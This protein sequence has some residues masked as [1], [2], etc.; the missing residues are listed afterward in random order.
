MGDLWGTFGDTNPN[1]SFILWVIYNQKP[2]DKLRQSSTAP[3]D[4]P[5]FFGGPNSPD[6][7]SFPNQRIP[8][9][10]N[11]NK[12]YAYMLGGAA[13]GYAIANLPGSVLGGL[14]VYFFNKPN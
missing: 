13:I 9:N 14:L 8:T 5:P 1:Y 10:N 12:K 6:H 4:N 2:I 3:M 11:N 7:S